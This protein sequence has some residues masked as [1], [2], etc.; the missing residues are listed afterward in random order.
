MCFLPP[1]LRLRAFGHGSEMLK[2]KT[3]GKWFWGRDWLLGI[4]TDGGAVLVAHISWFQDWD[5]RA[6]ASCFV[7]RN[8][9]EATQ[10]PK[11]SADF[12]KE[13]I[14]GEQVKWNTL[15]ETNNPMKCWFK[16]R[17]QWKAESV[18]YLFF[19]TAFDM[20]YYRHAPGNMVSHEGITKSQTAW[21]WTRLRVWWSTFVSNFE[22]PN[23]SLKRLIGQ[24]FES[25]KSWK[26]LDRWVAQ[27][28]FL[29]GEFG[30]FGQ[31]FWHG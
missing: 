2:R 1:Q 20:E 22:T 7:C 19:L 28:W 27:S 31:Q 14:M 17:T 10:Q 12:V 18:L 24:V 29:V 15:C 16:A 13:N 21:Q 4:F 9:P 25:M 30:T 23:K 6:T 11:T 3:K 26:D 5:R 8:D